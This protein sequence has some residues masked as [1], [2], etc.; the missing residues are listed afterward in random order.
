MSD[1]TAF[2]SSLCL[3]VQTG[4]VNYSPNR[5]SQMA[6]TASLA[7]NVIIWRAMCLSRQSNSIQTPPFL[8]ARDAHPA[9]IN[10]RLIDDTH[11]ALF[12]ARAT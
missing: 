12:G 9:G 4:T 1:K 6:L 5:E 8:K 3:W 2:K 10:T 7:Y 11:G